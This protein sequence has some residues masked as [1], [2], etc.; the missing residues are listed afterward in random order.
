MIRF[1]KH[2]EIDKEKWNRCVT[3]SSLSTFFV[4]FDFLTLANPQ[5]DALIEDDYTSVMPL[6]WRQKHGFKY[7]YNPFYFFR[8]GI[9][10][11]KNVTAELV[12]AFVTAIPHNFVSVEVN[13]NEGCPEE[14]ISD[15]CYE[16]VAHNLSLEL[17][18]NTLF[19]NYTGNNRRNVK[20]ARRN[21]PALDTN[22]PAA[23]V[24]DLFRTSHWGTDHSVKI[25]DADYDCF[26]RMCDFAT[27]R[28]LVES[29]GARD[30][31]GELLAG[32]IFL[33]DGN[34]VWFWTSG[35][36]EKCAERR[37]MY[38]LLD[39]YFQRNAETPLTF[40]FNG[41]RSDNVSN[42]YAGFGAERFT[43]PA[44]AFVNNRAAKPV[45]W[46]AKTLRGK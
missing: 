36:D 16:Q 17:P 33:H 5:W 22:V 4:D 21:P 19:Q 31:A 23:A 29:W 34:R 45:V 41:S 6:P 18:Y 32:A 10:S 20:L 8:L 28:G 3:S 40:T 25:K 7:I 12:T 24:V 11:S 14:G 39:E 26:L 46:L 9:F 43:Y 35:R 15:K 37:A 30:E 38:F 1:Y 13:L 44:L 42:F 27:K 2:S